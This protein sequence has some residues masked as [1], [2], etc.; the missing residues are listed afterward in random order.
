MG[1]FSQGGTMLLLVPLLSVGILIAFTTVGQYVTMDRL[2]Q[3][4]LSQPA[5]CG[6]EHIA[7]ASLSLALH[8]R[9]KIRR[10]ASLFLGASI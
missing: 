6:Q 4:P 8:G 7:Q 10:T 3:S 5:R 9:A 2:D 1:D